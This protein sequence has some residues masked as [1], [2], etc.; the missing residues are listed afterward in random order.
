LAKTLAGLAIVGLLVTACAN[1]ETSA[2]PTAAGSAAASSAPSATGSAAASQ[3]TGEVPRN[4]TLIF[5]SP[6]GSADN[7]WNPLITQASQPDRRVYGVFESLFYTN[8]NTGELIPW[9]A[10]SYTLS[11]DF[12]SVTL[13]LRDGVTWCD[14]E[15]FTADDVKFTIDTVIAGAP[16]LYDS[17]SY[18]EKVK[19]VTVVDPLTVQIDLNKPYPRWFKD[20]FTLGHEN[21]YNIV[22]KHIFDGQDPKTFQNYDLAKNWPC[23]T[24]PYHITS[25][26]PD[27][28][29]V[30]RNAKWWGTETGFSK[31]PAP[32]RLIFTTLGSGI[33]E[34][35][36][37]NLYESNE[38]D[39]C[40]DLQS[41][42]MA[43]T[44][45][46]DPDVRS[47]NKEGPVWGAPDGCSFVFDFNTTTAP[48]ND[49][50]VRLAFNYAFDRQ[51]IADLA[52]E[53]STH[54]E[55]IPFSSYMAAKWQ[56]GKVQAVLDK[57]DRGTHSQAKVDEYMGKAG[58]AKNA[59]GLWA[60]DGK[61][62]DVNFIYLTF[63]KP[64]GPV[65]EQQLKAAGFNATA[66]IDDKWDVTVFP[67]K[68]PVWV[69]VHCSSLT[70][71]FESYTPYHPKW[72]VANGTPCTLW[73]GC[74]RWKNEEM[75]TLLDKM[76]LVPADPSQ[77]SE[78]MSWVERATE[79]YLQ[80]MPEINLLEELHP[81][82][83]NQHYWTGYATA[84]DPY[85]A[86]YY[87]CWSASNLYLYHLQATGAQ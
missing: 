25:S 10:E 23:G 38:I 21:H 15:K 82:S 75:G 76:E 78:Y 43:A 32:D 9:Q 52:Y 51:Q 20:T 24:G 42:L 67:G 77:D 56:P 63:M 54:P 33:D 19:K 47:W 55:I 84:E 53:G 62:L 40:G 48:Y 14:G 46:K 39:L 2:A 79:I 1:S 6:G 16:D 59:D 26:T 65:L 60:K 73:M 17:A 37:A 3:A 7:D 57:Y 41:G 4:K 34:Q 49:V 13:K 80:E 87:C 5:G 66:K 61:T 27:Q 85:V 36:C 22:P 81:I 35:A 71:P 86:P 50:N 68:Q 12:T 45:A 58:F 28:L 72:A 11:P 74:S 18:K 29:V 31:P 30:D 8:L 44:T 83:Y 64:I 69:V 70:D